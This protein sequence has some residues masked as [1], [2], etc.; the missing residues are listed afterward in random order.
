MGNIKSINE[1]DT[2]TR[3]GVLGGSINEPVKA[4]ELPDGAGTPVISGITP[5]KATI[6]DPSFTLFIS[7]SNF[8]SAS[9]IVFAGQDEPTTLNADGTL[10][11]GINMDVWHG[12]D[13]VEVFI[14][15]GPEM[16]NVEYFTFN[17]AGAARSTKSKR[18]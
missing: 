9:V 15:N 5:D 17:E 2:P 14:K 16:S 12:P 6:G 11:T 13:T 3:P 8:Y 18:K 4:P 10:S 7:G 1:P